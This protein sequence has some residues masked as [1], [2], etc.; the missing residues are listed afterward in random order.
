MHRSPEWTRHR[1]AQGTTSRTPAYERAE[2]Y[3]GLS[4]LLMVTE[5][6]LMVTVV[7]SPKTP[8]NMTDF[9]EAIIPWVK[10]KAKL[11]LQISWK[12]TCRKTSDHPRILGITR[13]LQDNHC[14]RDEISAAATRAIGDIHQGWLHGSK[15]WLI[16]HGSKNMS[17]S[18]DSIRTCG[19]VEEFC[20]PSKSHA[21]SPS[22]SQ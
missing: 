7:S 3:D 16:H 14:D 10:N 4:Q 2:K 22:I 21:K 20:H 9:S 1:S 15:A 6:L 11:T 8:K 17:G 19:L 18:T 13:C 12:G 5:R